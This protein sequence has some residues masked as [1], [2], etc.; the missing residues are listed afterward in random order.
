MWLILNCSN[1]K[2]DRT[3]LLGSI[4]WVNLA[5]YNTDQ[6]FNVK[7]WFSLKFTSPNDVADSELFKLEIRS[8]LPPRLD[9]L[10]EFG[11]LQHGPR[12]QRQILVLAEVHEPERCG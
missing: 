11:N 3:S 10:G 9:H 5:T 2:S 4:T 8:D 1:W 7:Y 6:D 12:L